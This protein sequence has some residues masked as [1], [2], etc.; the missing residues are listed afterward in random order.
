MTLLKHLV[1]YRYFY[2]ADNNPLFELPLTVANEDD[3]DKLN[4]IEQ[5]DLFN[6]YV[7]HR[8]NS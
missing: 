1:D 4:K 5:K 3:L 2:P 6:Q 7:S 8:P